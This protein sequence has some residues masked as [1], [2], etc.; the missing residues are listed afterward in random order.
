ML[1]T[2][3]KFDGEEPPFTSCQT[4]IERSKNLPI[5]ITIDCDYPPEGRPDSED[6]EWVDEDEDPPGYTV[7]DL[8]LMLSIISPHYARWRVLNITVAE[9]LYM[10]VATDALAAVPSAPSLEVLQ[11]YHYA[12]AEEDNDHFVPLN[13]RDPFPVLFS[14]IAPKLTDIAL[15]GVHIS[16]ADNS[17][18]KGLKDMELAYH[19]EDVRPT[20]EEFHR[21]LSASP[22]LTVL[23]LCQSGPRGYPGEWDTINTRIIE[24]PA[25]KE[26]LI[27]YHPP[28]YIGPLLTRFHI[29][30]L[31]S[32]TMDFDSDTD[33]Y[34][35]FA[36]QLANAPGGNQTKSLL[37]GL[38]HL[39][40]SGFQCSREAIDLIY[41]QLGNLRSINLNCEYLPKEWF[42]ALNLPTPS[43][44]STSSFYCPLL[45]TVSTSGITGPEMRGF[46]EIRKNAGV[47]IKRLYMNEDDAMST[48]DETWFKSNLEEFDFFDGDSDTS[49]EV[50]EMEVDEVLL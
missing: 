37:K 26:L 17:F 34:S 50:V 21:V 15:W 35:S 36:L 32:L 24:L 25:L 6:D 40:I 20:W 46:V 48:D 38:E 4:W 16:W 5:D 45:D 43:S 18:L 22:D 23:S 33:D 13:Y 27:Q 49:D 44:S 47:P 10:R 39:K 1:W 42:H 12:E 31:I 30:N 7:D 2:S 29:P 41:E 3:I 9:Y 8:K 11:L 14:G 19:A 28:Q